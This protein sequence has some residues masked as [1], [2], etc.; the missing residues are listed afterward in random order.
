MLAVL[1]RVL[2]NE[3]KLGSQAESGWTSESYNK[4]VVALKAAGI[5]RTSKQVKSC[6]TRIKGQYK[7]MK[8]KNSLSGFG[9]DARTK[10]L[11]ATAEV[12]TAYLDKPSPVNGSRSAASSSSVLADIIKRTTLDANNSVDGGAHDTPAFIIWHQEFIHTLQKAMDTY[13]DMTSQMLPGDGLQVLW[14]KA[15]FDNAVIVA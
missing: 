10:T 1:I 9:F 5:S 13:Y 7:I 11:T 12:C 6:W 15:Q 2:L 8:D 3:K 14:D 4:V